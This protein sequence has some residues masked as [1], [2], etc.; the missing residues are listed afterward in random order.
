[1]RLGSDLAFYCFRSVEKGREDHGRK[2]QTAG[3]RDGGARGEPGG[4]AADLAPCS[5]GTYNANAIVT[6]GDS[7]PGSFTSEN[8]DKRAGALICVTGAEFFG[9]LEACVKHKMS[10]K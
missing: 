5:H 9:R 4:P 7:F 1:M 10:L 8:W 3:V 2:V 6:V